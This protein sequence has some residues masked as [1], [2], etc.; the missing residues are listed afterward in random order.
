M[1]NGLQVYYCLKE[2]NG[3]LLFLITYNS[4]DRIKG[5][6]ND[7]VILERW[8]MGSVGWWKQ[9][10]VEEDMRYRFLYAVKYWSRKLCPWSQIWTKCKHIWDR[11]NVGQKL[12]S[13]SFKTALTE[14]LIYWIDQKT[15]RYS[16]LRINCLRLTQ[17]IRRTTITSYQLEHLPLLSAQT[18]NIKKTIQG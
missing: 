9:I 1:F 5:R 12:P 8:K 3:I 13:L 7:S 6:V 4:F 16:Y 14:R 15:I 2:N 11:Y 10:N 18:H 17:I